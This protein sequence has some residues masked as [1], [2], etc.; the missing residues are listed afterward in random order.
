MREKPTPS[1]VTGEPCTCGRLETEADIPDGLVRFDRE[2][3]EFYLFDPRT[4][5]RSIVYHCYFCGGAAPLSVRGSLFAHVTLAE[6][7]RLEELA[8]G[9]V[10]VDDAIARFG[11]PD[12][13]RAAGVSL[14]M[15]EKDGEPGMTTWYKTLVFR[16]LSTSADMELVD[17]SPLPVRFS[18]VPKYVG[19]PKHEV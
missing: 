6:S 4:M 16:N 9:I 7:C 12:E 14:T 18:F 11:A 19:P 2:V 8:R 3:G 1:S 13:E 10:T 17:F 15:P 5:G